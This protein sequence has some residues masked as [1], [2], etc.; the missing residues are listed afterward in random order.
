[1]ATA[2]LA[3]TRTGNDVRLGD[4]VTV[5]NGAAFKSEYFNTE[6]RGMPLLRIRDIVRGD[7]RNVVRRPHTT[8]HTSSSLESWSLGWMATSTTPYGQGRPA[9]L[10]QRVCRLVFESRVLR[11]TFVLH[12]LA[13]YLEAVNEATPSV[14][15]QA[16]LVQDGCRPPAPASAAA[17]SRTTSL[18]RWRPT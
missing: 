18:V 6:G 2:C 10:N 8:R 13:G 3:S 11:K 15:G 16:S 9:L 7:H 1:M 4:V 17:M 14:H 12:A 5:Q